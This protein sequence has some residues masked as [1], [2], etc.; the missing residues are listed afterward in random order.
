MVHFWLVSGVWVGRGKRWRGSPEDMSTENNATALTVNTRHS[1]QVVFPPSAN[2][3]FSCGGCL[4][5]G[6]SGSGKGAA[7]LPLAD[8]GRRR[9][10][11]YIT[12]FGE[13]GSD[14]T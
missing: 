8:R 14:G 2:Q 6:G 3:E 13:E 9:M 5:T 11:H 7:L 1:E 4:C 12:S 10:K